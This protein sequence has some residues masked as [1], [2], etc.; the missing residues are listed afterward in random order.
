MSEAN[1]GRV[2]ARVYTAEEAIPLEGVTVVVTQRSP[3]GKVTLLGLRTSDRSGQTE[4]VYVRTPERDITQ[5]PS[6]QRG[7]S[8]VD[9]TA[10]HPAYQRIIVE[11]VQVFPGVVS[12]QEFA[13]IPLE[14]YPP[15]WGQTEVFD[16]TPQ[17]L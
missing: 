10:D 2:V 4:P 11:N 12:L 15:Q 1:S 6:E 14:E 9:V 3:V 17:G 8:T 16:V 7:F 13:M 5:S